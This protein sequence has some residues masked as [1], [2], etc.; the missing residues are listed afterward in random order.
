MDSL[1]VIE[2]RIH[3]QEII[4]VGVPVPEPFPVIVEVEVPV[5][6]P[7]PVFVPFPVPVPRNDRPT[8]LVAALIALVV[9]GLGFFFGH[10]R[11][12]AQYAAMQASRVQEIAILAVPVLMN[13]PDPVLNDPVADADLAAQERM[14]IAQL[15]KGE[16]QNMLAYKSYKDGAVKAV[17]LDGYG[18]RYTVY[19]APATAST[20]E[21]LSFWCRRNGTYGNN[22]LVTFSDE[23]VIGAASF[24]TW[25]P[26]TDPDGT[27]Y[28][29]NDNLETERNFAYWQE[30]LEAAVPSANLKIVG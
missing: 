28:F 17:F 30:W 29:R 21:L 1:L 9:G 22:T 7:F 18:A 2:E 14:L 26:K 3:T 6:E 19:W 25:G 15:R 10:R 27:Y 20:K 11:A 24:G 12:S 8:W 13:A 5:P 16:T 4:V 23:G